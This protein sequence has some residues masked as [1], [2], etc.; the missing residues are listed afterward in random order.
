MPVRE[1]ASEQDLFRL[2]FEWPFSS[3]GCASAFPPPRPRPPA[4]V[5]F[6]TSL[7]ACLPACQLAYVMALSHCARSP[8]LM[9]SSSVR[10]TYGY[11]VGLY[12]DH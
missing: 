8:A 6:C 1:R 5:V 10:S 3:I 4:R 2:H 7:P 12:A 9:A 11:Y